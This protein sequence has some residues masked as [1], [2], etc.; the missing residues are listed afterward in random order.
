ML[1]IFF[2]S[3]RRLFLFRE[4]GV[5]GGAAETKLLADADVGEHRGAGMFG[6]FACESKDGVLADAEIGGEGVYIE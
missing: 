6:A 1:E 4:P 2:S 3:P 5:N